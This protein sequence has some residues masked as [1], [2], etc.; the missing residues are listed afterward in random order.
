LFLVCTATESRVRSISV[1]IR[2]LTRE[3]SYLCTGGFNKNE[4]A[5]FSS[6]YTQRATKIIVIHC[7]ANSIFETNVDL[8]DPHAARFGIVFRLIIYP[9]RPSAVTILLAISS[10]TGTR[11]AT[12]KVR[13]YPDLY[14]RNQNRFR[15]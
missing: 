14:R 7:R 5:L 8:C 6:V 3:P 1:V 11:R 4:R 2:L 10:E 12:T 13:V 9:G 15:G